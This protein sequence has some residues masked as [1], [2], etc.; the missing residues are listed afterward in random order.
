MILWLDIFML[1]PDRAMVAE[2]FQAG[3]GLADK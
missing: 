1:A 3:T 2:L